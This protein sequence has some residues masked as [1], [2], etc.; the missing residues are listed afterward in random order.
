MAV[1][2][3]EALKNQIKKG[4]A[5]VYILVGDDGYL[6]KM[7]L[8]K[9]SRPI[10]LPDDIF[11]YQK[12]EGEC[13]LQE[14][15]DAVLQF[16]MM[17]DKKCV[18]LSD[19]NFEDCS[20]S[21]LEKLCTIIT[22]TPDTCVFILWFNNLNFDYTK[23]KK[24]KTVVSA[25]DKAGGVTAALNHRKAP[26][27]I[28]MLSD[29]ANKRGYKLDNNAA[30]Y[31][32]EVAGEDI[33]TLKNELEKL[34][35]FVNG[36]EITKQVIDKVSVKTIEASVFNLSKQI[37]SCDIKSALNTLDEL[38]FLKVEPIIVL[39]TISSYYVD[40]YRAFVG[41]E[42]GKK[43]EEIIEAFNYKSR[44]FVIPNAI[45]DL[46]KFDF[47]KLAL[48]FEAL[49]EADKSLK[50]FSCDKRTILEQLVVKLSYIAVKG[51]KVD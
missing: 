18:I 36:G 12:F 16:P 40:L 34:C 39:S 6:K 32:I 47:K 38:F 17:S 21:D 43:A 45:K 51:E 48:S 4:T 25:N 10:A 5:N 13:N 24:F 44:A 1:I 2:L 15:Y 46:S 23:S 11:N 9:I 29:G 30:R 35:F 8:E 27:L 49:C 20:K 19:Y 37:V 26:E 42:K 31:L 22:E 50:S 3:E 7:Y 14:V 28:K 33:N 41:K